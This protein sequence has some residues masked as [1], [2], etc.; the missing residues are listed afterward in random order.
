MLEAIAKHRLTQEGLDKAGVRERLAKDEYARALMQYVV[1]CALPED[2]PKLETDL[3]ADVRGGR[4]MPPWPGEIGLCPN[5]PGSST[6]DSELCQEAVTACVL[7]RVNKLE[8]RVL[9]SIRGDFKALNPLVTRVEVET[10]FREGATPIRSMQPCTGDNGVDCNFEPRYVG[11]CVAGQQIRLREQEKPGQGIIRVCKGIH[12][13]NSDRGSQDVPPEDE[14]ARYSGFIAEAAGRGEDVK[15][16]CPS[17]GPTIRNVHYGYYSVLARG[18][19]ADVVASDKGYPASEEQV[20]T[21]REG[22]FYGNLFHEDELEKIAK[23]GALGGDSMLVGS[24][25]ACYGT[26]WSK[27]RAYMTDR[28]CANDT[29]CFGNKPLPCLGVSPKSACATEG[30]LG[31]SGQPFYQS[32]SE[33][34]PPFELPTAPRWHPITVYLNDPCD[35]VGIGNCEASPESALQ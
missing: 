10:T 26:M 15:F 2:A 31:T 8:K 33:G 29:E 24:E 17:N 25:F 14:T 9:I 19:K 4:F 6:H 32:C 35:L 21:Y 12:G 30:N 16:V 7:A 1:S 27:A 34:G 3:G 23:A 5:W 22:A 28:F 20:F 13:C 18:T 11:R